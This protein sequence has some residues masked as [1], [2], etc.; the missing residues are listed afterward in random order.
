MD[1]KEKY[2]SGF[3]SGF[4]TTAALHPLEVLR[5]R[6]FFMLL[7]SKQGKQGTQS[8]GSPKS[9]FNGFVFN[10]ATSCIKHMAMYPTQ[11]YIRD[12]LLLQGYSKFNAE[13]GSSV[14]S[15]VAL[16]FCTTPINVIK[17]PI[18]SN[19]DK[20]K[21][22]IVVKDVYHNHGLRGFARGGLSTGLRDV[23]WN[24]SYFV[25]F[26]YL[27]ENYNVNKILASL[28]AGGVGITLSYPLD[29]GR[30]SLQNPKSYYSFWHGFR[31]SFSLNKINIGSYLTHLIRVPL[32]NTLS[33][34][35]YLAIN[36]L[37][38]TRQYKKNEIL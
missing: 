18:Q 14:G 3:L 21:V 9:F 2:A 1:V 10:T 38:Q 36:E 24:V 6:L 37:F 33:H 19:P 25:L 27:C 15:G 16:S 17:V 5:A 11:E 22:V 34:L 8:L 29:N 23:T 7:Q 26:H 30:L 12:Y 4:L 31:Q 28:L 20:S 32:A 35:T 13:L